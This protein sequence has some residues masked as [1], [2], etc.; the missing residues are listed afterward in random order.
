MSLVIRNARLRGHK[1][2]VDIAIDR[3]KISAVAPNLPARAQSEIDA[4]GNL[5]CRGFSIY[6][7]MPTSACWA[8]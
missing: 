4:K 5:Y 6:T 2:N 8:R 1:Q 3:E 7:I